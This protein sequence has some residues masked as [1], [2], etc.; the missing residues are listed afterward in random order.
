MCEDQVQLTLISL[1]RWSEPTSGLTD[2]G[3]DT[4]ALPG[5][6]FARICRSEDPGSCLS[7][8]AQQDSS[9]SPIVD[10]WTTRTP[11]VSLAGKGGASG[12]H[13]GVISSTGVEVSAG[14]QIARRQKRRCCMEWWPTEL[15]R[16][17]VDDVA[18]TV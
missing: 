17:C 15:R 1:R 6:N 12:A 4:P 2:H 3:A 18:A 9:A 7:V 5:P 13:D 10:T 11:E 8:F 14:H 16:L